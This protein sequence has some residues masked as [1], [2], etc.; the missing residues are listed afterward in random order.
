MIDTNQPSSTKSKAKKIAYWA[1]TGLFVFELL[2]G[3]LWDF[4]LVNKSYAAN[5]LIHLGYPLY[6]L[7]ILGVAK[8]LAA[9]AIVVPGFLRLKEWAYAGA[10]FIFLGAFSS[11]ILAG[12]AAASYIAP[13]I[14]TFFVMSS[15][16][17]RPASKKIA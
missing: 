11:H 7:I 14:F 17:L 15:Y 16:F 8:S 13:I 5:V 1:A 3:A 10:T 9:I 6:L 12:D 2:Y 4:N